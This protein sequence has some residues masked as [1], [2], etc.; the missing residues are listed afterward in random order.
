MQDS[1]YSRDP[2]SNGF[3]KEEAG[4]NRTRSPSHGRKLKNESSAKCAEGAKF[5]QDRADH[6][7]SAEEKKE[8]LRRRKIHQ[9]AARKEF[10]ETKAAHDAV[11]RANEDENTG[12]EALNRERKLRKS[13][14]GLREITSTEES[15]RLSRKDMCREPENLNR[16]YLVPAYPVPEGMPR[17]SQNPA[18]PPGWAA[19]QEKPQE[20]LQERRRMPR[21]AGKLRSISS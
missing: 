5:R 8:L 4:A 19:R 14:R 7:L 3:R 17:G 11:D 13:E 1:H 9:K 20:R 21:Q 6:V 18:M 12:T 16:E 2:G 10:L 15:L